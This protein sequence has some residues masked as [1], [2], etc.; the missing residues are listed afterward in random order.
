[1]LPLRQKI[2]KLLVAIFALQ[3]L[4]NLNIPAAQAVA[5]CTNSQF[6]ITSKHNTV[7][8]FDNGTSITAGYTAYLI[9]NK[10]SSGSYWAKIES[11]SGGA[12]SLGNY[13]NPVRSLGTLATNGTT[14]KF[15]YLKASSVTATAQN[16][17]IRFYSSDPSSGSPTAICE[18]QGGFSGGTDSTIAAAANKLKSVNYSSFDT[19]VTGQTFTATVKGQTGT[20]GQGPNRDYDVNLFAATDSSFDS[21][22][23]QLTGTRYQCDA[24]GSPAAVMDNLFIRN[25]CE[26]DYTATFTFL[27]RSTSPTHSSAVGKVSPIMQIASGTQMKHTDTPSFTIATIGSTTP[28]ITTQSASNVVDGNAK[29][30]GSIEVGTFTSAY[31]C[32]SATLVTSPM[33]CTDT[34]T[35]TSGSPYYTADLTG[36]SAGTYYFEFVGVSGGSTY[37]GGVKNFTIIAKQAG[38]YDTT[39]AASS[40][41]VNSGRINGEQTGLASGSVSSDSYFLFNTSG[42]S[43]SHLDPANDET[44]TATA[45]DGNKLAFYADLLNLNSGTKY[46]FELVLVDTIGASYFGGIQNFTTLPIV[47]FNPNLGTLASG[48]TSDT[49]TSTIGANALSSKPT[50]DPTRTGY[51][52]VGWNTSDSATT[53]LSTYTLTGSVT[54]YAV[55]QAVST[56]GGGAPAY[57]PAP[58]T[59]TSISAPEI[60]AIGDELLVKGTNLRGATAT[61]DG[62]AVRV[63]SSSNNELQLALPMAMA[64]TR[65]LKVTNADGSAS[66]TVKYTFVDTPV[67]VNYTYPLAYKD[68]EFKYTFSATDASRYAIQGR[69]PAGL[70]IDPLTGEVSGT[71]TVDGDFTFTIVAS[72]V[73]GNAY[74]NVYMFIDKAVPDAFTCSVAFNVPSSDNI[75]EIKLAALKNCL[76][77][78]LK[79]GPAT[80]D[81]VIFLSG[82]VP[83]GLTQDELIN[84]PRYSA[85]CELLNSMGIIAQIIVGSFDGDLNQVQIMVYWPEPLDV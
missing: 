6:T 64:G 58:P 4:G 31:F 34:V 26:G 82:G 66:T 15:W 5:T 39:T 35:A 10:G 33:A 3:A 38:V 57:V 54:L 59:I 67:Y 51:T 24:A 30:N 8:Y 55:W 50:T 53:A 60:C 22:R 71:P 21:E 17:Y 83:P 49:A 41:T 12:L 52:F 69:L 7:F 44:I 56:G 29:L 78:I 65:T 73:C 19:S 1:M 11:F 68:L 36:L 40:V 27:Y 43:G 62:A 61:I 37:V 75:S 18:L 77:E 48:N 72:N 47:T 46:Y 9:T 74:L 85:I 13:E 23:Y 70:T 32:K 79:S 45:V 80:M 14:T 76:D 84:H 25:A 28:S 42:S 20:I 63:I 81:P 16:Y 2:V